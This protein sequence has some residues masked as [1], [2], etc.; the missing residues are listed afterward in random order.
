MIQQDFNRFTWIDSILAVLL[1]VL[2]WGQLNQWDITGLTAFQWFP[3]FGLIAWMVMTTHYFTGFLM[4]KYPE[5]KKPK[6]YSKVTMYIVLGALIAHPAI[7]AMKMFSI[8]SLLPP[9]SFIEYVGPGLELSVMAGSFALMLFLSFE[10]FNR[11]KNKP[12]IK[13]YWWVVNLSQS[14][15]MTL[16]FVHALNLGNIATTGWF[17]YIWLIHGALMIPCIY[18]THKLDYD[19]ILS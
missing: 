16:I 18:Y 14:L 2:A 17:A 6:H 1:P 9:E 19:K 12:T 5:L 11:A 4:Q 10:F 15:A 8:E 7:L 13:K 3:L